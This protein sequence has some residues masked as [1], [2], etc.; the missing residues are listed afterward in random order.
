MAL[1]LAPS[2][3]P[4]LSRATGI[5]PERGDRR[6]RL[7]HLAWLGSLLLHAVVL[8]LLLRLWKSPHVDD[9]P[10]IE[11]AL[12]PG[13]GDAGKAG[14]T[15]GGATQ[16]GKL[17]QGSEEPVPNKAADA[18]PPEA[19][20]EAPQAEPVPPAP[21]PEKTETPPAPPTPPTVTTVTDNPP[22]PVSEKPVVRMP[23]P[24][25]RKPT[26]PPSP[27]PAPLPQV[28][29]AP[30]PQ[31]T[32]GTPGAGTGRGGPG[33]VGQGE[34][35][36]G[37][38]II[39]NGNGPGDD[40]LDRVWR[41]VRKFVRYPAVEKKEKKEG[42]GWVMFRIGRDG[43]VLEASILEGTG[44]SALDDAILDALHRASPVPPPPADYPG[45]DVR[46]EAPFDFHLGFFDRVF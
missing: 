26:P 41:H 20:K 32:P 8:A 6:E 15:G 37:H 16:E 22:A 24:P 19:V 25:P 27:S 10:V 31:P 33:G 21:E 12:V 46:L 7:R 23:P 35:G 30:I 34:S 2:P 36:S 44:Y 17:A 14:G 11:V 40:Y 5:A 3:H 9:F 42:T 18:E 39:G 4:P 43:T 13:T 38:G 45:P 1:G 28:A 29:T